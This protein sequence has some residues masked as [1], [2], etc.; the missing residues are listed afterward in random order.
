[1]DRWTN[2]WMKATGRDGS[3][4]WINMGR[5]PGMIVRNAGSGEGHTSVFFA[6]DKD[7]FEVRET[8][9]EL[10]KASRNGLDAGVESRK[11]QFLL[12]ACSTNRPAGVR[13]HHIHRIGR[14][15]VI[16][17]LQVGKR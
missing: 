3:V 5:A 1:M 6:G 8:P 4:I 2:R 16:A 15:N 10:L 9:E 13:D 11:P 17:R 14:A 7:P 12:V